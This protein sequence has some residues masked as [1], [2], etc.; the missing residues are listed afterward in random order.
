MNTEALP[1]SP[2]SPIQI[3]RE[4]VVNDA[5]LHESSAGTIEVLAGSSPSRSDS[6]E[7]KLNDEQVHEEPHPPRTYYGT[8]AAMLS[9]FFL[10]LL[11][12]LA[13]HLFYTHFD[14]IELGQTSLSQIWAIRI[15][16]GFAYLF[17]SALVGSISVVYAQAFWFFV[18]RRVFQI[19]SLDKLFGLLSNPFYIFDA[20]V[21]Q[22]LLW[23]L[24]VVS[25]L[26]PISAI[27]APAALTG[28][29]CPSNPLN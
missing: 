18:R 20:S 4:P 10:A 28:S 9:L 15:G 2:S 5:I 22:T 11:A 3:E 16:N 26:L 1:N 29:H 6:G 27:F 8:Y 25:W 23:G 12:A 19:D 17:K 21:F 7:H 14:Y 24:A 13:H